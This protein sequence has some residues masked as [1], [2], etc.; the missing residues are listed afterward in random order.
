MDLLTLDEKTQKT[1]VLTKCGMLSVLHSFFDPLGFT[2]P[3]LLHAKLI[4][5]QCLA[6]FINLGWDA[7]LPSGIVGRWIYFLQRLKNLCKLVLT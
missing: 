2:V 6:T 3:F 5:Q 4:Y 1:V 7:Q